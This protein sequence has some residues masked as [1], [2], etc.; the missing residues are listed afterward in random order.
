MAQ[1]EQLT[2]TLATPTA[3]PGTATSARPAAPPSLDGTLARLRA[4]DSAWPAS[5]GVAVFNGVYLSVTEEIA[6]RIDAGEFQDRRAAITLDA[7]FAE[8][9]LSAAETATAG[10]RPPAC[11]QPLFRCRAHPHVAPLQ[12]AMAGIN[13]H[14][15][16]DLALAVIDTCHA[17]DCA[18]PQL[19]S[20]FEQV[21]EILALLEERIREEVM[22]GPD[23]LELSGPL[24]HFIGTW[25]LERARGAAW[26]AARVLWR[27]RGAPALGRELAERLDSGVGLVGL[28]ILTPYC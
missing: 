5:D 8:R 17:L 22:P 24:A 9:Y 6:R 15:G 19:R 20:A 12:F 3:A 28:H 2:A 10:G 18:P 7:L 13:A 16:H 25:S 27:L 1:N 14:I 26:S 4:L 11:W 23:L 21:G